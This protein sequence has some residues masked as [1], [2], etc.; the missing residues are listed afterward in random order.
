MVQKNIDRTYRP[1]NYSNL[2]FDS[3]SPYK[4][5]GHG[6]AAP[7]TLHNSPFVLPTRTTLID[8]LIDFWLHITVGVPNILSNISRMSNPDTGCWNRR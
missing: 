5:G 3:Q 4:L 8:R 6:G 2:E 1:Q 7:H